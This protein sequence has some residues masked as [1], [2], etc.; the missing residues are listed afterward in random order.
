M[1]KHNPV[2]EVMSKTFKF[3]DG[4]APGGARLDIRRDM[5]AH[6]RPV[7][8][9]RNDLNNAIQAYCRN[10]T[11]SQASEIFYHVCRVTHPDRIPSY[12]FGAVIG[13][14][15]TEMSYR[16]DEALIEHRPPLRLPPR[17]SA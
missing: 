17:T 4:N 6:L 8:W 5:R 13:L 12:A 9:S 10:H 2:G 11:A 7:V 3:G 15:A 1:Q 16:P 14:L